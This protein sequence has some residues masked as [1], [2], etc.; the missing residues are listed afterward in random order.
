MC[1]RLEVTGGPATRFGGDPVGRPDFDLFAWKFEV[2][3]H[4]THYGE[5]E[6]IE[7]HPPADDSRI[8]AEPA[9]PEAVADHERALTGSVVGFIEGAAVGSRNAQD[10]EEPFRD[11]RGGNV[12]GPALFFVFER[13]R[14]D[15]G[16]PFEDGVF[17]LPVH[18]VRR[19][20]PIPFDALGEIA[21][22]QGVDIGRVRILKRSQE[23]AV[24]DAEHRGVGSDAQR[25]GQDRHHCEPGV[26]LELAQAE[27]QILPQL[28]E[29]F[30]P[31]HI[32][33]QI[34]SD[35]TTLCTN[36]NQVAE[37]TTGLIV[38]IL[39]VPALVDQFLG[40]RFQVEAKLILE[41]ALDI[42]APVREIASPHGCLVHSLRSSSP[43][44][45][46]SGR[47]GAHVAPGCSPQSA[48][49]QSTA[50]KLSD[51]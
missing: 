7:A 44:V 1:E 45:F 42:A 13:I 11:Q 5:V 12:E 29:V 26:A 47:L 2:R 19:C 17:G 34:S 28:V 51:R 37:S 3:G 24:D 40:A 27:R 48:R 10:L 8:A 30:R 49:S 15:R 16:H 18:E 36:L 23:H 14:T 31:S 46:E 35:V 41:V 21:L 43:A 38:G 20:N 4:D 33:F 39:R 9:H 50:G 32:C 22:P 25:Q 6:G